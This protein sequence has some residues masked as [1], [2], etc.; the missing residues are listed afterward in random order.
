M[1]FNISLKLIFYFSKN[2]CPYFLLVVNLG[3]ILFSSY[4][5]YFLKFGLPPKR[6]RL[7]WNGIKNAGY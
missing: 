3:H 2:I 1:L 6:R 7:I 5:C 4:I